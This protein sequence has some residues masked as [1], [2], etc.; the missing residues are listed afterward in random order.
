M[1]SLMASLAVYDDLYVQAAFAG[2]EAMAN[3]NREPKANV[4]M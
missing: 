3:S 2:F 4:Y 1:S